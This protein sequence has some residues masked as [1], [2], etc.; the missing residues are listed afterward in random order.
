MAGRESFHWLFEPSGLVLFQSLQIVE[1]LDEEHVGE[2][3]HYLQRVGNPA[4]SE[5]VPDPIDLRLQ[6]T[7]D[8]SML[9]LL[10]EFDVHDLSRRFTVW[11]VCR[12]GMDTGSRRGASTNTLRA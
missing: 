1:P 3:L 9:P 10:L 11:S 5:R 2:L 6:L 7:C 8:H 12:A 4:G